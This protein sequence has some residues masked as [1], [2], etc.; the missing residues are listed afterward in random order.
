MKFSKHFLN[1]YPQLSQYVNNLHANDGAVPP[2]KNT[3]HY[4]KKYTVSN[5]LPY[6]AVFQ[7]LFSQEFSKAWPINAREPW[8]QGSYN[9]PNK[10][11]VRTSRKTRDYAVPPMPPPPMPD[12]DVHHILP[13]PPPPIPDRDV[14]HILPM[15][16]P[17]MPDRDVH[18][19]LPMPPPPRP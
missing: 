8:G 5:T 11:P 4:P 15:P 12:R 14:H 18:H 7:G 10:T 6:Q 2:L 9:D 17:P 1:K 13:M 3:N 19:K 16:P